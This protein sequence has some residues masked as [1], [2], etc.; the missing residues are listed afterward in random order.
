[1]INNVLNIIEG[2]SKKNILSNITEE[3][4]LL[5]KNRYTI[6]LSCELYIKDRCNTNK[7]ITDITTGTLVKGCGC[8]LSAKVFCEKCSCPAHRW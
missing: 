5:A 2:Y 4:K 1:M 8:K 3:A 7:T 6:C